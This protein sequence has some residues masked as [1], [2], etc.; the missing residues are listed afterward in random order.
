MSRDAHP[1]SSHLFT[2]RIWPEELGDG[3]IEWRGKAQH[4]LTGEAIYFRDWP[5]LVA[6]VTKR[7]EE[8]RGEERGN[9][10]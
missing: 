7:F 4:V 5:T 10:R 2:L 1:P 6:F 8:G 3:K 9:L